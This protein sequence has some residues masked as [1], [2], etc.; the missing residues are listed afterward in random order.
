MGKEAG[1]PIREAGAVEIRLAPPELTYHSSQ[2]TPFD[3]PCPVEGPARG[4]EG[5]G[6]AGGASEVGGSW[7]DVA[8]RVCEHGADQKGVVPPF[9]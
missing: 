9:A 2:A 3:T 6:R 8:V 4:W 7:E 5:M 1:G